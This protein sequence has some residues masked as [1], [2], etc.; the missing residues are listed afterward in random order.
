MCLSATLPALLNSSSL[1]HQNTSSL[2][3]RAY[4]LFQIIQRLHGSATGLPNVR[5]KPGSRRYFR[6]AD[7]C[8]LSTSQ[9]QEQKQL[10]T[11][12]FT[13]QQSQE[14]WSIGGQLLSDANEVGHPALATGSFPPLTRK[15]QSQ[16]VNV[17]F[18]G[19]HTIT[20]KIARDWQTL[21]ED[22][23]VPLKEALLG[24]LSTSAPLAYPPA[25][26][27][28]KPGER[29]VLRKLASAVGCLD[30]SMHRSAD[31]SS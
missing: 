18:F 5:L 9:L 1:L 27:Q 20:I 28:A 10:Q 30:T 3:H 19:A 13:A 22:H 12:L 26:Q 7:R 17:R 15:P 16:D 29:I 25:T 31:G 14:A 21:P 6:S 23:W 2:D 8:R 24:W 11:A 4:C